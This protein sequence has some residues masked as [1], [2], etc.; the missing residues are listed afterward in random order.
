MLAD[1]LQ[2]ETVSNPKDE[3]ADRATD[4]AD[5]EHRNKCFEVFAKV[6]IRTGLNPQYIRDGPEECDCGARDKR[7]DG[8]PPARG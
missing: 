1:P 2:R 8:Q 7:D 4:H 5:D 6:E 3:C